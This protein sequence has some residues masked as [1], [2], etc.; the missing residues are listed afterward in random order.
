MA[1]AMFGEYIAERYFVPVSYSG[2]SAHSSGERKTLESFRCSAQRE[3]QAEGLRY[4]RPSPLVRCR[5]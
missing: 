2:F 1:E 4:Y 5:Q 3:K